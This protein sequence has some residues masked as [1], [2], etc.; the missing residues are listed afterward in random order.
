[1]S[2]EIFGEMFEDE[3]KVFSEM[4]EDERERERESLRKMK[5]SDSHGMGKR[6]DIRI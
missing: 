5:R 4:F 6:R 1:M 3:E 2:F